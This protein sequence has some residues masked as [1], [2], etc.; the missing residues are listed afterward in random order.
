MKQSVCF[1]HAISDFETL[2]LDSN[3]EIL[4]WSSE[5]G[6]GENMS[7]H[8]MKV[9]QVMFSHRHCSLVLIIHYKSLPISTTGDTINIYTYTYSPKYQWSVCLVSKHSCTLGIQY[10]LH[11]DVTRHR[12]NTW[13]Q[14]LFTVRGV[15]I[16]YLKHQILEV[17]LANNMN[18]FSD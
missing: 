4:R 10:R 2:L 17:L 6:G 1:F 8:S 9:L 3:A 7:S 5:L 14:Y 11:S 16:P 13:Y 15:L 18:T 12:S